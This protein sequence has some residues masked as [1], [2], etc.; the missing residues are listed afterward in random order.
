M[1]REPFAARL[2]GGRSGRVLSASARPL[3]DALAN[4]YAAAALPPHLD[5]GR[6]RRW[7]DLLGWAEATGH[8][9]YQAPLE[10]HSGPHVRVDGHDLLM[11]SAYDYLGLIGH[12]AVE[13]AA[14]AAVRRYGTGSGGVRLLTGTSDLHR[15]LEERVAAFKGTEAAVTFSSGYLANIGIIPALVGPSD[16]VLLDGRAHRSLVAGCRLAGVPY[17]FFAHN[18]VAALERKLARAPAAGTLLIVVEGVYSMDGDVCPLPEIVAL[19]ERYGAALLVDEAHSFGVLGATGRGVD[20][21]FGIPPEKVD[22]WVGS[23][24]TAVP[25]NGGFVAV[26]AAAAL[27]L[28]HEAAP[29]VFSSAQCPAATAAALAALDVIAAEPERIAAARH[30]ADVLRAGLRDLGF[31]TG[32]SA[33]PIVPVLLGDELAAWKAARFLLDEGILATAVVP[34]AVPRGAARLRLCATAGHTRA[35][36]AEVL[37]AFA[38]LRLRADH[39]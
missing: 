5:T 16:R 36:M 35:D 8:Y 27:Y 13:E 7:F 29:F 37:R 38:K 22:F 21:H 33:S 4:G 25:A 1:A 2:A 39:A 23:L 20:Q 28:Q 9:T 10:G 19:K 31:D 12:R 18:D 32:A 11:I 34:P 6:V 26:S 30:N 3:A 17:R 14:V 15:R 24:S